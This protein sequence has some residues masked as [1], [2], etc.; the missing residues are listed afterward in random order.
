MQKKSK[1]DGKPTKLHVVCNQSAA[2]AGAS[3]APKSA[4]GRAAGA[5]H[6]RQGMPSWASTVTIG[7]AM[8]GG[9][10]KEAQDLLAWQGAFGAAR[11]TDS[12]APLVA[13]LIAAMPLE[14]RAFADVTLAELQALPPADAS[15]D[16]Y[17][18]KSTKAAANKR[19]GSPVADTKQWDSLDYSSLVA[20]V[21]QEV[22]DSQLVQT[23]ATEFACASGGD[24]G[25]VVT[26]RKVTVA[27]QVQSIRGWGFLRNPTV[28][29]TTL[30]IEPRQ[31]AMS[32]VA[33][34]V[35]G[36]TVAITPPVKLQLGTRRGGGSSVGMDVD[37]HKGGGLPQPPPAA[38]AIYTATGQPTVLQLDGVYYDVSPLATPKSA[39][40]DWA[41]ATGCASRPDEPDVGNR[42]PPGCPILPTFT[43]DGTYSAALSPAGRW[44]SKFMLM[45]TCKAGLVITQA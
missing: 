25:A 9:Q 38:T 37:T 33:T 29:Q 22:I 2:K 32:A 1:G 3:T 45:K 28:H 16:T 42:A 27:A 41:V 4:G 7:A 15:D 43:A 13:T 5:T 18:F 30:F 17:T 10:I 8:T 6:M 14:R 26:G 23:A 34:I 39:G 36:G 19:A 12:S 44:C 11:L 35:A 21:P 40:V 31:Q 20:K 24:G